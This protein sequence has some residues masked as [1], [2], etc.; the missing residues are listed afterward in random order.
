MQ[1]QA[2]ERPSQYRGGLSLLVDRHWLVKNDDLGQKF[3]AV[4]IY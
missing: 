2:F 1:A 4:A 3:D